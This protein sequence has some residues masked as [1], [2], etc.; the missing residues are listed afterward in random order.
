M[1]DLTTLLHDADPG[2]VS[3]AAGAAAEELASA[4]PLLAETAP[5][6]RRTGLHATRPVLVGAVVGGLVLTGGL[7]AAAPSLIDLFSDDSPVVT[8]VEFEV[9]SGAAEASCS[10]FLNVVPADGQ[11]HAD[12]SGGETSGGSP[13][14]FDQAELDAVETFLRTHDWSD[15]IAEVAPFDGT[16]V[17]SDELGGTSLEGSFTSIKDAVEEAL[18]AEGLN[19]SG[20]A[21]LVETSQCGVGDLP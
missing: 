20:S 15:V 16:T 2:H 10:L 7:A 13:E 4:A 9:P 12:S 3:T 6:D 21:I 11:V 18:A 5:D 14:T 8:S 19:A 1:D 17:T